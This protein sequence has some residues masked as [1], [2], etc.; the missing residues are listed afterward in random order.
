M[1]ATSLS[2]LAVGLLGACT[3]GGGHATASPSPAASP[4]AASPSPVAEA[5]VDSY[6][7]SGLTFA[8]VNILVTIKDNGRTVTAHLCDWLEIT[9]GPSATQWQS[10]QSTDDTT[11]QIVPLPLH[12][13]PPGGVYEVYEAERV[14]SVN[15][16]SSL[17]PFGL[18]C[19][20]TSW[21]VK[22]NVVR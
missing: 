2:L 13:P 18:A 21:V 4:V 1:R 10:I 9:L 7:G 11:L 12:S 8:P 5:C 3:W 19:P 20:P 16:W 14:G 22:V 17:C 15:L 6:A